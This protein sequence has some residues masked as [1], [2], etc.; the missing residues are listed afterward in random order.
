MIAFWTAVSYATTP[1]DGEGTQREY[2]SYVDLINQGVIKSIV[3]GKAY[4]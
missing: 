3:P 4:C 1:V 2:W